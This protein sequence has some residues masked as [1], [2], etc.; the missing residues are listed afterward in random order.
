MQLT[1]PQSV[2]FNNGAIDDNGYG[3]TDMDCIANLFEQGV[4]REAIDMVATLSQ[5]RI[6]PKEVVQP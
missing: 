3:A 5:K 1:D 2:R 6:F 4:E